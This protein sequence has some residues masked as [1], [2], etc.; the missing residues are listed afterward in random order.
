MA[1]IRKRVTVLKILKIPSCLYIHGNIQENLFNI[2][3]IAQGAE[4]GYIKVV[5]YYLFTFNHIRG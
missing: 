1:S 4:Y 2:N 5:T 3:E